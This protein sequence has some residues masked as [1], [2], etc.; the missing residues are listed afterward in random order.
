MTGLVN[1]HSIQSLPLKASSIFAEVNGFAARVLATLTYFNDCEYDIEG[2]FVFPQDERTTIV[3]FEATVEERHVFTEIKEKISVEHEKSAYAI[4]EREDDLFS[5]SIGRIP[6][7]CSVFV[8]V[9][10][11][12]ELL[13]DPKTRG[14]LFILPSVFTPRLSSRDDD[15]NHND[16]YGSQILIS[17]IPRKTDEPYSFDLQLEVVAPSLLAGCSSPTHAIQVDADSRA[18]NASRIHITIAEP[19]TYDRELE[20][21]LHLSHPYDPYVLIEEGKK[22]LRDKENF[23]CHTTDSE[24]LIENFAQKPAVMINFTPQLKTFSKKVTEFLFLVDRSGSMSGKHIFQ[25]KETLILFLKSLPSNCYFNVI[26]F[27]S[28]YRSLFQE[29]QQ[30]TDETL[31]KAITYVQKMRADLGGTNLILP[32]DFIF[33]QPRKNGVPRVIFML[34]DGGVSNTLE[35]VDLVRKNSNNTR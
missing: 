17:D 15:D 7:Q 27:G 2:L 34:T 29:S 32:L 18:T 19:H 30:Y 28:Y 8:Q 11:I 12:T 31:E 9:S 13:S 26:G 5:L 24:D 6:P 3:E 16:R 23:T 21:L 1:R 20:V 33:D 35:V 10:L 25:V 22:T 14:S 4:E